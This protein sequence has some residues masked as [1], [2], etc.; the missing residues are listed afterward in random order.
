MA[1][2]RVSRAIIASQTVTSEMT[3]MTMALACNRTKL[4][5]QGSQNG[6][7]TPITAGVSRVLDN[8]ASIG[9][10]YYVSISCYRKRCVTQKSECPTQRES[11]MRCCA[12]ASF[13]AAASRDGC[14]SPIIIFHMR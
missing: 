3:G 7:E 12:I 10:Q 14:A 4:V 2:A 11:G 1:L 6:G 5:P 8:F 13:G 9:A